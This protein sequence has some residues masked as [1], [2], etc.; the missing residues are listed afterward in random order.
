MRYYVDACIWRDFLEAR[1]DNL[2]PLGEFAFQ[3]LKYAMTCK[4]TVLY[5]ELVLEELKIE[6]KVQEIEKYCFESLKDMR[7]LEKVLINDRQVEEARGISH[8]LNVPR[9]DAL[10]AVLARD[11]N[12]V[13]VT[14]D[15][16]FELLQ[17]IVKSSKPEEII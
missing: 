2:K 1:E 14:R 17:S 13:V 7:L 12:A 5:S 16:H 8:A 9:G 6:Y 4:H 15:N 11:N 10:H 3:F